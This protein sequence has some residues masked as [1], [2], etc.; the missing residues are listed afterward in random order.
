[1]SK[2]AV[3]GN[4]VQVIRNLQRRISA[5]ERQQQDI[6]DLSEIA[7][8]ITFADGV[9]TIDENGI[10]IFEKEDADYDPLDNNAYKFCA[11]DRSYLGSLYCG[12]GIMG[13]EAYKT[14]ATNAAISVRARSA[15]TASSKSALGSYRYDNSVPPAYFSASLGSGATPTGTVEISAGN[16]GTV[17]IGRAYSQTVIDLLESVLK[18]GS[19]T[20]TDDGV[21]SFTPACA[22]GV[23]ILRGPGAGSTEYAMLTYAA[24]A[25]TAYAY[26]WVNGSN[27]V[28]TTGALTGTTGTDGKLTISAHT[29]GKIYIENRRGGSRAV[30][31]NILAG[32]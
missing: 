32:V 9:V 8:S 28:I 26:A 20:I 14:D 31:W 23:L 19:Q 22:R 6:G 24:V 1:M 30:A 25:G 15:N 11:N 4:L 21:Y 13:L 10:T 2:D 17:T 3:E 12:N 18:G 5:L 29:D 27:T 16:Q 7:G